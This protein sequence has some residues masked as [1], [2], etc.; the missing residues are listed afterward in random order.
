MV[1]AF[2][3]QRLNTNVRVNAI[4]PGLVNTA[5]VPPFMHPYLERPYLFAQPT[6]TYYGSIIHD[7]VLTL[8]TEVANLALFLASGE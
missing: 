2:E 6:R 1:G 8:P 5:I 3:N 4:A 7:L